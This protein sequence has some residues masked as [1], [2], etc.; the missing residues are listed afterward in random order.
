MFILKSMLI[1]IILQLSAVQQKPLPRLMK[2][3]QLFCQQMVSL[4]VL[5]SRLH[6]LNLFITCKGL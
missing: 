4:Q 6:Y 1:G 2:D 5:D 3:Q